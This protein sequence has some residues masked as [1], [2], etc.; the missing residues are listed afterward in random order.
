MKLEAEIMIGFGHQALGLS[1]KCEVCICNLRLSQCRLCIVEWSVPQP[2]LSTQ[3]MEFTQ[4]VPEK[5]RLEV[6]VNK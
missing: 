4:S 3:F 5:C 6:K 2:I 1:V